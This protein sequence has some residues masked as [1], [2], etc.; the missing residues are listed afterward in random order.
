MTNLTGAYTRDAVEGH[1]TEVG[2]EEKQS[3]AEHGVESGTPF[4][5]QVTEEGF[6]TQGL[7]DRHN[8]IAT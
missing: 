7:R 5:E 6:P 2:E 1:L 8:V 4:R 3:A